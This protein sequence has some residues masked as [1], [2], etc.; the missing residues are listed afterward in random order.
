VAACIITALDTITA[1]AVPNLNCPRRA[2]GFFRSGCSS[3]RL[4]ELIQELRA[5]PVLILF[6]IQCAKAVLDSHPNPT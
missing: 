6:R 1:F 5:A 4:Q 2:I 3:S